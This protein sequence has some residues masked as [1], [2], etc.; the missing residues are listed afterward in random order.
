MSR[1]MVPP[2]R[3]AEAKALLAKREG[4]APLSSDADPES[5]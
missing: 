2:E 5:E 1:V 3:A 4:A